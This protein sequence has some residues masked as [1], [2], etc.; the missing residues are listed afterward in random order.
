MTVPERIRADIEQARAIH[1]L[2]GQHAEVIGSIRAEVEKQPV[3]HADIQDWFDHLA[4]STHLK[5]QH[6]TWRPDYEPYYF[7]QLRQRSMTW[8]L[9]RD[10]Y[11]F[12]WSNVVIAEIPQRGHATY[13]FA[14]PEDVRAFM[15]RYSSATRDDIRRNRNNVATHLG[16]VRRIVRGSKMKR[17]LNDVLKTAGE[18]EDYVEVFE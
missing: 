11:L 18:K 1:T 8:F 10:E 13:V 3:E 17:W 16:F 15:R 2:L 7:E 12:V 4:A 5:P 14:K 9:F 6:V